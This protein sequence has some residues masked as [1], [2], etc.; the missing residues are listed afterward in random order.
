MLNDPKRCEKLATIANELSV[1]HGFP[2][3][4]GL[5]FYARGWA[6]AMQGVPDGL[7]D[8]KA[9]V[10]Q[11]AGLGV[12]TGAPGCMAVIAELCALEGEVEEGFGFAE[13][14]LAMA[15]QSG[16][17]FYTAELHRSTALLHLQVASAAGDDLAARQKALAEAEFAA[18]RALEVADSQNAPSLALRAAEPLQRLMEMR[19]EATAADELR[20]S[21]VS[22]FP[23]DADIDMKNL[24]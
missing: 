10:G 12:G 17:H 22:R 20:Q 13:L 2:P 24:A 3:L 6:H 19:G 11:L 16:Q 9:G 4:A 1:E 5:S 21:I 23:K 18:K 14:G 8:A 7:A 15:E